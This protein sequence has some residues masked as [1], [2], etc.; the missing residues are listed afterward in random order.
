MK[1]EGPTLSGTEWLEFI[2]LDWP[3]LQ[4]KTSDTNPAQ[5]QVLNKHTCLF[6]DG[7]GAGPPKRECSTALLERPSGSV[8]S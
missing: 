5:E 3:L 6:S 8:S 4:L 7:L 1:N 2:Q